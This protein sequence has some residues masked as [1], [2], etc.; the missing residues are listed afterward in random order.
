MPGNPL[1]VSSICNEAF[2]NISK[3][4][5]ATAVTVNLSRDNRKF[6]LVI[7]DN[8]RDSIPKQLP[9]ITWPVPVTA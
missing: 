4:A 8:G 9:K 6:H 3:Y 1:P 7:T 5:Q 2:N